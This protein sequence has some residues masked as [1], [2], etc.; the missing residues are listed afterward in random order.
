MITLPRIRIS[1]VQ[2]LESPKSAF[3]CACCVGALGPVPCLR[4]KLCYCYALKPSRHPKKFQVL[5]PVHIVVH[6]P[7]RVQKAATN[8]LQSSGGSGEA[9]TLSRVLFI[10]SPR[11]SRSLRLRSYF[12]CL[13][14]RLGERSG[15][16]VQWHALLAAC[17]VCGP[18]RANKNSVCKG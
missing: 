18:I 11:S 14:G 8:R 10:S 13:S 16:Q 1:K 15:A 4:D 7:S 3:F 2:R 6:V 5:P 12:V 9:E 17:T